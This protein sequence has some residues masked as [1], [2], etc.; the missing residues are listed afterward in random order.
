MKLTIKNRAELWA[1]LKHH[2]ELRIKSNPCFRSRWDDIR[3]PIF[4]IYDTWIDWNIAFNQSE[5]WHTVELKRLPPPGYA[6]CAE[7]WKPDNADEAVSYDAETNSYYL[8][9][10]TDAALLEGERWIRPTG[11]PV[12]ELRLHATLMLQSGNIAFWHRD[13][14]ELCAKHEAE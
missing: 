3:G 12:S 6:Y 5:E 14:L 4:A 8:R 9:V 10:A 7:A 11:V 1:A 2:G 13:L